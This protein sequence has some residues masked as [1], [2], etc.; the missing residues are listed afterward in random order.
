MFSLSLSITAKTLT[1]LDCIYEKHSVCP[2]R[3]RN[4]LPFV[5]TWDPHP[6]FGR[7]CVAHNYVI[8]LLSSLLVKTMNI[9]V[10][11]LYQ[12][13]YCLHLHNVSLSELSNSLVKQNN[14]TK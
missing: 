4:Y 5:S 7:I 3:S 9:Y 10:I 12:V 14:T 13:K 8:G 6:V 2:I 1:E 11:I